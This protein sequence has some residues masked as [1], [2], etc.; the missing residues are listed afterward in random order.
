MAPIAGCAVTFFNDSISITEPVFTNDSG[1]AIAHHVL[2]SVRAR[3]VKNF[4][5]VQ[6]P[7]KPKA[8]DTTVI[9]TEEICMDCN[10]YFTPPRI[11]FNQFE[12]SIGLDDTAALNVMKE[13]MIENPDIGI[14]ISGH[15]DACNERRR[16]EGLSKKRARNVYRWLKSYGGVEGQLR[17]SW[18]GCRNTLQGCCQG[19]DCPEEKKPFD[20]RVEFRFF[21]PVK[22]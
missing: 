6:A 2:Q 5:T 14:E 3:P 9:L 18:Y 4:F 17:T 7:L 13:I 19:F 16:A 15:A 12:T 22:K 21:G 11:Y 20:R 1:I 10:H 8:G